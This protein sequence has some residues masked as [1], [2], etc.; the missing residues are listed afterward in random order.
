LHFPAGQLTVHDVSSLPHVA[1][2]PPS[3]QPHDPL[4]QSE[5]VFGVPP[6]RGSGTEGVP[7]PLELPHA[8]ST[9]TGKRAES[10]F[11]IARDDSLTIP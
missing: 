3:G 1:A 7:T 6:G 10:A 2:Q 11:R 8:M 4:L 5:G 9:A